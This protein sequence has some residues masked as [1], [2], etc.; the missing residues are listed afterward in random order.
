MFVCPPSSNLEIPMT[1][2]CDTRRR[3]LGRGLG[4]EGSSGKG[5]EPFLMI[6]TPESSLVPSPGWMQWEEGLPP[7]TRPLQKRDGRPSVVHRLGSVVSG[8]SQEACFVLAREL[9]A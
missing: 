5:W 3:E 7:A 4:E 6:E 9:K 1:L 8:L 2:R